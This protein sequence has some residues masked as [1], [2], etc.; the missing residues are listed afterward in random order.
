M[1]KG[2]NKSKLS[3]RRSYWLCINRKIS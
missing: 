3:Y 1:K 2:I